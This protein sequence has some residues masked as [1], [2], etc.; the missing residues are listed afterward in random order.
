VRMPRSDNRLY[1]VRF[2]RSWGVDRWQG[3]FASE[4]A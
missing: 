3:A 1:K 2:R 4:G